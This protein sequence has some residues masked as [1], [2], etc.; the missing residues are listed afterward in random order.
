MGR[1]ARNCTKLQRLNISYTQ[2][3]QLCAKE[4]LTYLVVEINRHQAPLQR[5]NL[6][7]F[8]QSALNGK[9]VLDAL[10]ANQSL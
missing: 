7:S 5:L 3:L 9:Q 8:N 4:G 10:I 2:G 6:W 1:L